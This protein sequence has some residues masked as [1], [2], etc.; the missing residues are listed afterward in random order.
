VSTPAGK[1]LIEVRRPFRLLGCAHEVVVE[2]DG[3]QQGKIRWR[4]SLRVPVTP[5]QHRVRM[6]FDHRFKW[7]RV[8]D[9]V[10]DKP[11]VVRASFTTAR[12]RRRRQRHL[13]NSEGLHGRSWAAVYDV[14]V[15]AHYGQGDRLLRAWKELEGRGVDRS[16]CFRY[17]W[18]LNFMTIRDRLQQAATPEL[19]DPLIEEARPRWDQLLRAPEDRLRDTAYTVSHVITGPEGARRGVDLR[20]IAALLACLVGEPA[21]HLDALRPRLARAFSSRTDTG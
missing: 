21:E 1:A 4:G 20:A 14:V 16:L 19:L 8:V 13:A 5:G 6:W 17:L 7:T 2:V 10:A 3:I 18:V 11:S 9:V 15:A 12:D